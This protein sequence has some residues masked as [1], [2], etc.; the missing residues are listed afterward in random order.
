MTSMRPS[1]NDRLSQDALPLASPSGGKASVASCIINLAS[2]CM[3]T[4]ILA[5]PSA[6]HLGGFASGTLLCIASAGLCSLSLKLLLSSGEKVKA[7]ATFA[8]VCEAA[9]PNSGLLID[10]AVIINCVGCAASYLIVAADCFSALGFPRKTCVLVAILAVSPASLFRNLDTLKASS[11][12]AICCLIGI[13][14]MVVVMGV[15]PTGSAFDPC[16]G[17][18]AKVGPHG[19][20]GGPVTWGSTAPMRVFCTL[21]LFVNAYTCQQNVYN[22]VG[23]LANPTAARKA[24]VVY[25]SPL[26]PLLLYLVI[27]SC[28]YLTFGDNV[29]SNIINAYPVTPYVSAARTVLGIVVLCNYP[30]QIF[31]RLDPAGF[32]F[33]HCSIT[34]GVL[35]L[36]GFTA[37]SVTDLGAIVSLVGSTGATMIALIAPAAAHLLLT[38]SEPW[39]GVKYAAAGMLIL[40]LLILPSKLFCE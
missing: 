7:P 20:C 33:I 36:T 14:L 19:H 4:G 32:G 29:T 25:G 2:T 21:P 23:E 13:V 31:I 15:V 3:G 30:L 39:D 6:Y 1:S 27:A 16:P 11:S 5:L 18:S 10:F 24:Q 17:V 37:F 26:L 34:V 8:T 22:A 28:G 12:V 40:G 38:R 9:L 35:F